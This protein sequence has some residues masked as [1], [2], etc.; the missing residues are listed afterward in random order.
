[1]AEKEKII[2]LRLDSTTYNA[3]SSIVTKRNRQGSNTNLS[4][5]IR[6]I[7]QQATGNIEDERPL[8]YRDIK[9]AMK[10]YEKGLDRMGK[11]WFKSS[12]TILTILLVFLEGLDEKMGE[13]KVQ[14]RLEANRKQAVSLLQRK[15]DR[16]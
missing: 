3:L 2:Y 8:K 7:L 4:E 16:D 6:G 15:E 14:E 5:V 1:M 11:L 10:E 13:K 12:R 9:E